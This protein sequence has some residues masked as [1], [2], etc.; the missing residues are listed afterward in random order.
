MKTGIFRCLKVF[1]GSTRRA[2]LP[3]PG[4]SHARMCG[5]CLQAPSTTPAK[6]LVPG[7][8]SRLQVYASHSQDRHRERAVWPRKQA[9]D[10]SGGELGFPGTCSMG[11][12]SVTVAPWGGS[13]P[14]EGQS[15]AL[16][17][18]GPRTGPLLARSKGSTGLP[19]CPMQDHKAR[20]GVSKTRLGDLGPQFPP[21]SLREQDCFPF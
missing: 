10:H 9:Q 12:A 14:E 21:S 3:A 1:C 6:Q 20:L 17:G 4:P 5:L 2:G 16:Q 11:C 8:P 13:W 19:L 18:V 15:S 7:H